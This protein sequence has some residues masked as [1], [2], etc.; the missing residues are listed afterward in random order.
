VKGR[1]RTYRDLTGED[2]S[3]LGAQVAE[4]LEGV[5]RRLASVRRVVAV[6]SGK[7]GVGK[8]LVTAGLATSLAPAWKV[9]VL[10]ADLHGPTAAGLLGCGSAP[11][12]VTGDAAQPAVGARGVRVISTDL[13]LPEG[14]P[15]RWKGPAQHAHV[16]RGTMEAGMLREFLADVAWG[17]LDLLLVD[18]P[19][20]MERLIS[21]AELVPDLRGVVAVTLP[22]DASRR[23]VLRSLR[24]AAEL[25]VDVLGI[26][27]NMAGYLCPSCGASG[28]L[29]SGDAARF[30][31]D[32][33]SAPVL[34]R[35]PFDPR[36]QADA[37]AGRLAASERAAELFAPLA[38]ALRE[39]L[40]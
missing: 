27:E 23:S 5:A 7:G 30:L 35:I 1:L 33:T 36:V 34:A 26:V 21:L 2:R 3:H 31:A 16:W 15:L 25:G 8:S 40:E 32:A 4:Q 18:L 10:D 17:E 24:L 9:G 22:G 39:R 12:A 20:G 14:A 19:P 37:D 6:M 11:L 29:F 13:L 38:L 28:P